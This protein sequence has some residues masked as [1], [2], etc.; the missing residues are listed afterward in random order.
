VRLG[1][2]ADTHGTLRPEVEE[3]FAKV[4]LIL[5][6]GDVG[7]PDILR[8]LELLAPVTAVYGNVDGSVLRQRLPRVAELK[9]DGFVFV[10]THGDQYGFP[11]PRELKAAFPQADVVVFGHTHRAVLH[12]FDDYSVAV[13]PGAAGPTCSALPPSVAI[14]ETEPGIPP[15]GRIV[16]LS[17]GSPPPASS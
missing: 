8:R 17:A 9:V 12:D 5:H 4:D 7:D 15:R 16:P 6:A 13:N 10:V 2:L 11:S 1:I 3:I 14:M